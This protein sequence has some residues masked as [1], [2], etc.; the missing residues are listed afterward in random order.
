MERMG[1]RW[2]FLAAAAALALPAGLAR[3]DRAGGPRH[4]VD[5]EKELPQMALLTD[6]RGH[7]L[8]LV[9]LG[10]AE[11]T[12][13]GDGKVFHQL[14]ISSYGRDGSRGTE[15][16][17]FWAPVSTGGGGDIE[18]ADGK[19]SVRC[20]DRTTP[21]VPVSEAETRKI[22]A[23]APFKKPLWK[24]QAAALGRDD[25]GVY[26]Q[27]DQLRI[28]R[29]SPLDPTPPTGYRL[30]IGRKG[31]L[32]AQKLT[33]SVVDSRGIVLS[34]RAG[35]L[36]VDNRDRRMVWSTGRGKSELVYLP[37]EDNAML[38][39]RDLGI[40]GRLGIPCDDM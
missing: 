13:Y 17:R 10:P 14:R 1:G 19:W 34:T 37:V 31:K 9:P 33:D 8:A 30:F 2:A 36:T 11:M 32:K 6:G 40:H 25:T 20:S 26:Y 12:F 3:A 35:H 24:R 27:V 21:L 22:L 23:R 4:E 5:V 7:Y 28:D 38:I 18:H 29:T 16:R 15:S 39:Y